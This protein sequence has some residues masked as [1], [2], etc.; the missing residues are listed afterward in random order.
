VLATW[1]VRSETRDFEKRS[2]K[3]KR[4]GNDKRERACLL[5]RDAVLQRESAPSLICEGS[6]T[7]P[8][9][10]KETLHVSDT[11]LLGR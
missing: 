5:G 9:C 11:R 2:T 3:E 6:D 10:E 8:A 4:G 7:E 1:S